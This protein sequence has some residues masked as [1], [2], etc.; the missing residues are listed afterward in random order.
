MGSFQLACGHP[1]GLTGMGSKRAGLGELRAGGALKRGRAGHKRTCVA[2]RDRPEARRGGGLVAVPR[3]VAV[4]AVRV[5]PECS[6]SHDQLTVLHEAAVCR[7]QGGPLPSASAKRGAGGPGLGPK[8]SHS[9]PWV[10]TAHCGPGHP[11]AE[12][13]PHGGTLGTVLVLLWVLWEPEH[14]GLG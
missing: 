10:Q 2:L 11:H 7:P 12:L 1:L 9:Q 3:G 8:R 13:S 5:S 4:L 14:V 6:R